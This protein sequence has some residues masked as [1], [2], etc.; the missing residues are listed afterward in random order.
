MPTI[1]AQ[2]PDEICGELI[3]IRSNAFFCGEPGGEALYDLQARGPCHVVK[4]TRK[5]R[6]SA[7]PR[8]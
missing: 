8:R 6:E 5:L 4:Q 2:K 1:A 7:A 3:G